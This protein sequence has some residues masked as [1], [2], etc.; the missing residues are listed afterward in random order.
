MIRLPAAINLPIGPTLDAC[1]LRAALGVSRQV[2]H[3]WTER[4]QPFPRSHRN[5]RQRFYI[6]S[7]VETWL[8]A[9]GVIVR[10]I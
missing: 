8:I 6:T 3:L 5:G 7:E 4:D 9:N 10:R 2:L 1:T